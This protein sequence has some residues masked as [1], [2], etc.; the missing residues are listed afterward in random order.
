M[1]MNNQPV[2]ENLLHEHEAVRAH[3]GQ[4][5][6]MVNSW[7]TS[8]ISDS[9]SSN[10][11]NDFDYQKLN[12]KQTIGYLDD[13]LKKQF[14]HEEEILP[15]LVGDLLMDAINAEH[16]EILKELNEIK[17]LLF[18]I[19]PESIKLKGDYLKV[20]ISSFTNW[21][22]KNSVMKDI[23]LRLV[24]GEPARQIASLASV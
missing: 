19:N 17:F 7:Y 3:M 14:M 18:Y 13:G 5:A 23:M 6:G 8:K 20:L 22:T 21:V 11:L 10:V 9:R 12:L 4:I 15:G 1:K 24:R 16:R 2:I